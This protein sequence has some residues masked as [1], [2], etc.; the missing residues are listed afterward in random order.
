[1]ADREWPSPQMS[2]DGDF[3]QPLAEAVLQSIT[4]TAIAA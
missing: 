1:M 3:C 4:A 2:G